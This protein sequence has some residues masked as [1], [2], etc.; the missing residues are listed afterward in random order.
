MS[1]MFVIRRLIFLVFVIWAAATITF[2]IPR[3]SDRNP[4]RQ[5]LA[6]LAAQGGFASTDIEAMVRSYNTKFGL[7][8][9]LLDQYFDYVGSLA[10]G[11]LGVS[12]YK[13][14]RTVLQLIMDAVP[15]TL[16]LLLV[17][18]ILSFIIG[19]L[20]GAIAAWPRSPGWLRT[21][22]TQFIL[23]QGVPPALLGVLL[24]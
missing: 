2:F 9:T 21:F 16:A 11:D 14:P 24:L 12:L 20:L 6:Q 15:W 4:V 18:T 3:L 13:Y 1:I 23:L 7:D 17:T 19:N 8:K 5:R 22:A 10:R